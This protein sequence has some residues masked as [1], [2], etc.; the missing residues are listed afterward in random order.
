MIG[1]ALALALA[2][3]PPS[4]P[5]PGDVRVILESAAPAPA[6]SALTIWRFNGTEVNGI[7]LTDDQGKRV[8][9]ELQG[10]RQ[11]DATM[12]PGAVP[13]WVWGITGVLVGGTAGYLAVRR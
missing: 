7:W 12:V 9:G 6:K 3:F 1:P 11:A 8:A 4:D 2:M 13:W 10:C 5:E